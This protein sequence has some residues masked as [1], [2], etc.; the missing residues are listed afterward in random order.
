MKFALTLFLVI[1]SVAAQSPLEKSLIELKQEVEKAK[2]ETKA[3]RAEQAQKEAREKA[4]RAARAKKRWQ[5]DEG[6]ATA[7]LDR[8][9]RLEVLKREEH[10]RIDPVNPQLAVEPQ[11]RVIVQ[12]LAPAEQTKV[13]AALIVE[14]DVLNEKIRRQNRTN[15]CRFLHIGCIKMPAVTK[16]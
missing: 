13:I 8:L 3:L 9:Q 16:K 11:L 2:A 12:P 5:K 14:R 4:D 15:L 1:S 6:E 7:A 10:E